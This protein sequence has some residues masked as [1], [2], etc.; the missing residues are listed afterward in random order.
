MTIT[1]IIL[2]VVFSVIAG[3]S[4]ISLEK[5]ENVSIGIQPIQ[6]QPQITIVAK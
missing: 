4:I 2:S 6:I 1:L 3:I 5:E